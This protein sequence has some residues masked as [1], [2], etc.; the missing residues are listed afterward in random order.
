LRG[1]FF[2][3]PELFLGAIVQGRWGVE[4]GEEQEACDD[5]DAA[6]L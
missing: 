6:F 4:G 1:F 5:G 3:A 2:S